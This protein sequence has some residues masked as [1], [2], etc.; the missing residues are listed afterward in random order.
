MNVCLKETL[1][2]AEKHSYTYKRHCRVSRY[3]SRTR[4]RCFLACQR[5]GSE[6]N[7]GVINVIKKETVCCDGFAID[8]ARVTS[9]SKGMS[10]VEMSNGCPIRKH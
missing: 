9:N 2:E 10:L 5:N 6:C 8:P 4:A 1:Y 7:G 3:H